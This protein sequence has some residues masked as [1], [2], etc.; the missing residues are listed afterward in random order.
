MTAMHVHHGHG[1]GH[2]KFRGTPATNAFC[3]TTFTR[4]N[5]LG[6]LSLGSADAVSTDCETQKSS[7]DCAVCATLQLPP[8]D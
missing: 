1:H 5:Y 8:Q 4:T 3:H 7:T 6:S 2:G